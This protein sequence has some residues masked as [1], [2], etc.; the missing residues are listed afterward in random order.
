MH[1]PD[2]FDS[3]IQ[4]R[5]ALLDAT[6]WMLQSR[7]YRARIVERR[8]GGPNA[9]EDRSENLQIERYNQVE[10][11]IP[12]LSE[13]AIG[14]TNALGSD[15]LKEDVSIG[16]ATGVLQECILRLMCGGAIFTRENDEMD[17]PQQVAKELDRIAKLSAPVHSKTL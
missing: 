3:V 14:I 2:Y 5:A 4:Y 17:Y 9:S 7:P 11:A 12:L 13:L 8:S 1:D 16:E 15:D 6:K 10:L